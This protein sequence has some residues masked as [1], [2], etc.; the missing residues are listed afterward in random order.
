MYK[1]LI[2]QVRGRA[3]WTQSRF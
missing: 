3:H 2:N 1:S